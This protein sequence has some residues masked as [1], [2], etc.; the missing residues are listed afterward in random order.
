VYLDYLIYIV[1]QPPKTAAGYGFF[2]F[3]SVMKQSQLIRLK[4]EL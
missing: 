4:M 3:T 2:Y 1:V